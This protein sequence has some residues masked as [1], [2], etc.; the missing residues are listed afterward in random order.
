MKKPGLERLKN[1][2]GDRQLQA[3]RAGFEHRPSGC[4]VGGLHRTEKRRLL[5]CVLCYPG[6]ERVRLP[7]FEVLRHQ[8]IILSLPSRCR[9]PS[10]KSWGRSSSLSVRQQLE[11]LIPPHSYCL[12][13][14]WDDLQ[15]PPPSKIAVASGLAPLPHCSSLLPSIPSCQSVF[16][17]ANTMVL[18]LTWLWS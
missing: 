14:N 7:A 16:Y 13:F 15:I 12:Y 11:N 2:P 17:L 5:P 6:T 8:F 3:G 18:L 9:F 1:V 4:R 10:R